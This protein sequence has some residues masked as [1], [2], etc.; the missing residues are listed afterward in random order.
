MLNR[1]LAAG[2]TCAALAACN[3]AQASSPFPIIESLDVTPAQVTDVN[4]PF[5]IQLKA[6]V[7]RFDRSGTLPAGISQTGTF[8]A[9][10]D[11][12]AEWR[13]AGTGTTLPA[14]PIT[15]PVAAL[16]SGGLGFGNTPPTILYL[17][18]DAV[19][20]GGLSYRG[21]STV[22]PSAAPSTTP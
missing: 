8:T 10:A 4:T 16:G 22:S 5:A 15:L 9:L 20:G 11:D 17:K 14:G 1:F 2:L 12:K 6:R 19:A 18:F 3:L 7:G 13:P 21:Y